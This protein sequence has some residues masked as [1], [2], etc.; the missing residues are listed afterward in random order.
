METAC[1][2]NAV[3]LRNF[4]RWIDSIIQCS[5]E[6]GR[7]KE[8]LTNKVISSFASAMQSNSEYHEIMF[9]LETGKDE[10]SSPAKLSHLMM[11]EI[12]KRLIPK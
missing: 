6:E 11:S 3:F 1:E 7:S 9:K 8:Y 4:E 2:S 10:D 5:W 12:Y